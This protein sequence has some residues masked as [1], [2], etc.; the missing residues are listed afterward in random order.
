M[1]EI[2][3]DR[4][5]FQHR[6]VSPLS[7]STLHWASAEVQAFCLHFCEDGAAAAPPFS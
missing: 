7:A 4:W 6:G 1:T 2:E 5:N 3:T